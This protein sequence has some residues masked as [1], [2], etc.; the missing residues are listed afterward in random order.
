MVL[1]TGA[2]GLVG[3]NLLW[4]LLQ[5]NDRVAAICRAKS[6]MQQLRTVFSFYT[7]DPDKYLEKIDWRMADILDLDSLKAAMVGATEVYHCAAVVSLGDYTDVLLDTN[8][9]GTRNIVNLSLELGVELFCF[10]SSIAACGKSEH[11]GMIDEKA[12]W[13][14]SPNRSLYSKSK[15]YSEQ[16]VWKGIEKGLRAIIVNPGVILGVSGNGSGSSQLFSQVQK[17]LIF[18]TN[19]GTGYVDVRDVAQAMIQLMSLEM[20]GKRFILVAENNSNKDILSWIADGFGKRRP[21]ICIGKTVFYII[22]YLAEVLG[23]IFHFHP[24]VNRATA[25]TATKR[26]YYENTKIFG[27]IGY[28]FKP[29]NQSI[30]EICE[31]YRGNSLEL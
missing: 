27:A 29:I 3:G 12:L 26:E 15:Y 24:K 1:V 4:Y 14:D 18:Y 5:D 11:G 2:T 25:R 21:F 6:N 28:E 16:E 8:V 13:V 10:V 20:C 31:F 23:K 22:G 30:K 19:G 17:G 9:V 7:S